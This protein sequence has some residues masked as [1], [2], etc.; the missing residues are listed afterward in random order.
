MPFFLA[1]AIITISIIAI[2]YKTYVG[3]G[4]YRW[5]TKLMFLLFLVLSFCAPFISYTVRQYISA[6]SFAYLNRTLYFLFGFVFILF[7]VSF[8]RDM[9]WMLIDVI[10]KAPMDD[11]KNPTLLAKANLITFLCCLCICFYGFYEAQ[12]DAQIVTYDIVSSKVKKPTKIVALADLHID[13]DVSPEYVKNLVNRINNLKPDA[14]L[15]VGDLVDNTPANLEK[16]INEF[17]NL[18]PKENIYFVLGNHEYYNDALSWGITLARMGFHWLGNYGMKLKDTGVY[19]AGIHDINSTKDIKATNA[20]HFAEKDD[21]VIMM[22]H[23]PKIAEGINK[24]NVDLQI[25]GHTH[26]GQI[27]PF[28]Y[29]VKQAND[30]HIAGYYDVDG[31]KLYVTRGTRY[32]GP[33]MRI[34]APSEITVFNLKPQAENGK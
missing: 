13:V 9:L 22:S 1:F 10:R 31:V 8:I 27:Y 33:P 28:H 16:Q 23:T 14:I 24:D 26:G 20:L 2:M 15:I 29:F 5:Y 6:S 3:Y 12:K 25:S 17:K 34:L 4:E 30:G 19:I 11:M 21:Y 7:M 32:W 18:E